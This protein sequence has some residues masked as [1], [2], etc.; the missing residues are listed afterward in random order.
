MQLFSKA[1][2]FVLLSAVLAAPLAGQ[3]LLASAGAQERPAGCHEDSR[4]P[5]APGPTSHQCCQ[6]GHDSAIL[7]PTP[8]PS[9]EVAALVQFPQGSFALAVLSSLP[10]LATVSGDP[11]IASPLRV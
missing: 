8:G 1:V 3:A 9:L 6:G 10:N 11:P 4:K 2:V 5:P 7:L